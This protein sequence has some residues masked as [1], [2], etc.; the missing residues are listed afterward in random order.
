MAGTVE[1][2]SCSEQDAATGGSEWV[3]VVRTSS[4]GRRWCRI[5][6]CQRTHHQTVA[7]KFGT[8]RRISYEGSSFLFGL[9]RRT[10]RLNLMAREHAMT[11]L[12]LRT[13]LTFRPGD[14]TR[15]EVGYPLY[16]LFTHCILPTC[17]SWG[18]VF[19]RFSRI[20]DNIHESGW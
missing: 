8:W 16:S 6:R 10:E 7:E 18:T 15:T 17:I 5:P 14:V 20:I 13:W 2:I 9:A 1:L 11:P 3:S 12:S 19:K 4:A